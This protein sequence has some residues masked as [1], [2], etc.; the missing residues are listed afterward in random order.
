MLDSARKLNSDLDNCSFLTNAAPDLSQFGNERFDLIV[1]DIVLQHAP[2]PDAIEHY[3]AEF[4][5]VLSSGG[6]LI[7]QLPCH[8]PL[9]NRLQWRRRAYR[10]LRLLGFTSDFL[11]LR[12][13][14]IP[15]AMHAIPEN[16]VRELISAKGGRVVCAE[17]DEDCLPTESRT[18]WVTKP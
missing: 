9:R 3:L 14:L 17:R 4:L 13:G 1:S 18:Y 15:M 8:I 2:S 11:Y 5:R 7:F 10:L 16:R 6:A 12:L